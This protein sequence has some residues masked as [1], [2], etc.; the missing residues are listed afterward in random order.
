MGH[1]LPSLSG[2]L[3]CDQAINSLMSDPSIMFLNL[4]AEL[5]ALVARCLLYS[6]DRL[7]LASCCR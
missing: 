6:S 4:P 7:R 3:V 2:A 5:E 1:F